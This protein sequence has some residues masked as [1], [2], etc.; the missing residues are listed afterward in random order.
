MQR[1]R[2]LASIAVV[3]VAGLLALAGCRTDPAVAA[4]VGSQRYTE[5]QVTQIYDELHAR[6]LEA[7]RT[8]TQQQGQGQP[9]ASPSPV[10]DKVE[11]PV[12]R[13][14]V[15]AALI[16]RDV[17]KA[18]AGKQGI[19]K[20]ELPAS[21]LVQLRGLPASAADTEF[22]R[23][24]AEHEGYR[25][26]LR[27]GVSGRTPTETELRAL[28]DRLVEGGRFDAAQLPFAQFAS[29]LNDE[30]RQYVGRLMALRDAVEAEVR[31]G[32]IVVNPRYGQAELV[33]D[34][35]QDQ[36]R[37]LRPLLGVPL[38]TK[39]PAVRDAA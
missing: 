38:E 3:T 9:A 12:T 27:E 35:F 11:L 39:E 6:V 29:S 18:V 31:A 34:S 22:A 1:A 20:A 13:Q 26:A 33:V 37:K 23:V 36:A 4:Y 19:A 28:F 25:L 32:D 30:D 8:Q 2:R 15:V 7:V 17:L 10:P 14:E 21:E 5:D 24:W 16:G